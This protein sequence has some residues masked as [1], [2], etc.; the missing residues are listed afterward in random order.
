VV[1][2]KK[3]VEIKDLNFFYRKNKLVLKDVNLD[4][5]HNDFLAIIGPN[6]GGKSTL[7]KLILGILPSCNIRFCGDNNID[8]NSIGYVP[9]DISI[10]QSFFMNALDVVL[11]G[12]LNNRRFFYS[13]KE[14]LL[15]REFLKQVGIEKFWNKKVSLMSGGEVQ[16][17]L[18]ARSLISNPKIL[19]LDEP[20]SNIDVQGQK[21]IYNL[22]KEINKTK[23][24]VVVSHDIELT[25]KYAKRAVFVNR[26]IS[27]HDE[28]NNITIGENEHFCEVELLNHLKDC[29]W[30]S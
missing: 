21:L 13:K 25:L 22:L 15:A 9:Q 26:T 18:I 27:I 24:V 10:H 1:S 30:K 23:T 20:T 16:R 7:I 19:I 11:M 17:V 14:K 3:I 28:V 4:I 6:G 29:S 12:L 8:S 2:D 5:Y